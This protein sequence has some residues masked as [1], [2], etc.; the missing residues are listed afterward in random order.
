MSKQRPRLYLLTLA[1]AAIASVQ[2]QNLA[3]IT[4]TVS[5]GTGAVLAGVPIE[6][7]NLATGVISRATT[8]NTG[9]YTV[10]QLPIGDYSLVIEASGFKQ[11][12]RP[13]FHLAL[14]QTMRED[15]SLEVGQSTESITVTADSSLM[16]TESSQV[17]NNVTLSQLNT[18][19]VLTLA[20]SNAGFRDPYAAVN[21]CPACGSPPAVMRNRSSSTELR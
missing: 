18:L 5:D 16:K 12:V 8:T 13:S 19:P 14:S 10:S 15:V 2:A 7:S 9:N 17:A 6:V 4:G 20:T 3:T 1:L 21:S 11:Y